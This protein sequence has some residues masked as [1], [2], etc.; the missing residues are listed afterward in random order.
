MSPVSDLEN[1]VLKELKTE[2]NGLL[3]IYK[4][5]GISSK[6]VSRQLTRVLGKLKMGHVGTLDP[7]AE[8]V[9]P[10]L[11][12]KATRLQD[13]LLSSKK[14]YQCEILLGKATDT[15]DSEGDFVEESSYE[16]VT[17][18]LILEKLS[19]FLGRVEQIP[20]IYSALKYKGNP[21]YKYARAGKAEEVPLHELKRDIEIYH[22][23]LLSFEDGRIVFETDVS[24][25]TY[26]RVLG[27][28]LAKS[29]GTCAHMTKLIRKKSSSIEVKQTVFLKDLIEGLQSGASLEKFLI[30]MKDIPMDFPR[31]EIFSTTDTERLLQGQ[32]LTLTPNVSFKVDSLFLERVLNSS[33]EEEEVL[34]ENKD[35]SLFALAVV[36]RN[37]RGVSFKI[38]KGLV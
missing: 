6:D 38:Q 13:Y 5:S 37:P 22:L 20:P 21:L 17:K 19:S 34:L 12:G 23:E 33:G 29:L 25:G 1:L 18:E 8:G 30:P 11:L 28:D 16:H 3:P 15:L 10:I 36:S 9:L 35:Y 26:I 7:I 24:K 4:P 31:C 32:R 2:K 14:T 27:Y